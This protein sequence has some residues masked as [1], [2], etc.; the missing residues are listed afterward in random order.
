M[1]KTLVKKAEQLNPKAT[2]NVAE[3]EDSIA[4]SIS[5]STSSV[6]TSNKTEKEAKKEAELEAWIDDWKQTEEYKN[7]TPNLKRIVE[8]S[9]RKQKHSDFYYKLCDVANKVHVFTDTF[10]TRIPN[11]EKKWRD[12]IVGKEVE[13]YRKHI[14]QKIKRKHRNKSEVKEET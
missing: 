12:K 10:H 6:E 13:E 7:L 8:E 1:P 9:K 2:V 4:T 14:A 3:K 11:F 5:G